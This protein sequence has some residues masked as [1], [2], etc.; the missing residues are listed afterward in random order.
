M[1]T[2]TSIA[3]AVLAMFTV[4]VL[5]QPPPPTEGIN[6]GIG[7]LDIRFPLTVSQCEPV[8]IYYNS[9]GAGYISIWTSAY[10]S[11]RDLVHLN[12][13]IGIGYIVWI[14]NIPAGYI[15]VA[16]TEHHH[17]FLVQPGPSSC[18]GD[19]TT[20][21]SYATYLTTAFQSYT[22]NAPNTTSF[23][24]GPGYAATYV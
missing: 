15:F 6:I 3:L 13:P 8:L 10:G 24:H 18:L 1:G 14:C 17:N 21:Y 2:S 22:S 4:A 9:T 20:T 19:V 16:G 5:T 12:F 11:S 7:D 23:F